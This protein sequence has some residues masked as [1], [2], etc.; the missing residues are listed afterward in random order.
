MKLIDNADKAERIVYTT[1]LSIEH[2]IDEV[3]ALKVKVII[4]NIIVTKDIN[5]KD[6]LFKFAVKYGLNSDDDMYAFC[7]NK[8]IIREEDIVSIYE[9]WENWKTAKKIII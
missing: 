8:Y 2:L 7:K 9:L 1:K 4:N 5:T 6:A 3:F